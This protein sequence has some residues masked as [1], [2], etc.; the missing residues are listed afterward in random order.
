MSYLIESE[1]EKYHRLMREAYNEQH[2]FDYEI[3]DTDFDD[4]EQTDENQ[5]G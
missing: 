5:N 2:R 1:V 4:K 3:V